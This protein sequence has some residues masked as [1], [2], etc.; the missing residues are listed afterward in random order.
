MHGDP[1]DPEEAML[2]KEQ[3]PGEEEFEEPVPLTAAQWD[4]PVHPSGCWILRMS[5]DERVIKDP[6]QQ[7]ACGIDSDYHV[8][9]RE[10]FQPTATLREVSRRR[11]ARAALGLRLHRAASVAGSRPLALQRAYAQPGATPHSTSSALAGLCRRAP[12]GT[13]F[14]RRCWSA[15]PPARATATLRGSDSWARRTGTRGAHTSQ[16]LTTT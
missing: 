10:L 7:R 9:R 8:E 4:T 3:A 15:S 1:P 16:G 14:V 13:I 5:F 12:T 11:P 6:E 2:Y